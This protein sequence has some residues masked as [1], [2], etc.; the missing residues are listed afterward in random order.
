M[1][2]KDKENIEDSW[3]LLDQDEQ[4]NRKEDCLDM[5]G[6]RDEDYQG[7][8]VEC[9]PGEDK[10]EHV[11]N[12]TKL[13]EIWE[14]AK[15]GS[16]KDNERIEDPVTEIH[17]SVGGLE[18]IS[19]NESNLRL[20][21][22]NFAEEP[23]TAE[24]DEV[25]IAARRQ[26]IRFSAIGPYLFPSR[27]VR[28]MAKRYTQIN[29]ERSKLTGHDC[30]SNKTHHGTEA[31]GLCSVDSAPET[32]GPE[33]GSHTEGLD[34]HLVRTMHAKDSP[35]NSERVAQLKGDPP[36]TSEKQSGGCDSNRSSPSL[37]TR[38]EAFVKE[39]SLIGLSVHCTVG[40]E[41]TR[42]EDEALMGA[43]ARGDS[44]TRDGKEYKSNIQLDCGA[45]KKRRRCLDS[46][47][48]A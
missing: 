45:E 7:K 30:K 17:H 48:V 32:I 38:Y 9:R 39:S 11:K 8:Q 1:A 29:I 13:E 36:M 34:K 5:V 37:I 28:A 14:D 33:T 21:R 16:E 10:V 15:T 12:E 26:G 19:E 24:E 25:L 35:N 40:K 6:S 41:W 27:P 3:N 44:W 18:E 22:S 42:E 47:N 31:D 20:Q 43:R 23:W 2:I 46:E 4:T